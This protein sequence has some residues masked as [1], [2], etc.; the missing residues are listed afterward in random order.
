MA[1][2]TKFEIF[3]ELGE[4]LAAYPRDSVELLLAAVRSL[5]FRLGLDLETPPSR[6]Q[7]LLVKLVLD[8]EE[9]ERTLKELRELRLKV[10]IGST[11]NQRL[12]R[13]IKHLEEKLTEWQ[14]THKA[15]ARNLEHHRGQAAQ[16]KR[17]LDFVRHDFADFLAKEAD[18]RVREAERLKKI[19]AGHPD[20]GAVASE[21]EHTTDMP[22]SP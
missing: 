13:R 22:W 3:Q 4:V 8:K 19:L 18:R 14:E 12:I 17:E 11:D 21:V 5:H 16:Y 1:E 7:T 10:D 6:E 9:A 20:K 2:L 15:T